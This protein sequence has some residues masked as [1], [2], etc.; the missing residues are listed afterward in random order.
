MVYRIVSYRGLRDGGLTL[1][2]LLFEDWSSGL[3]EM[4]CGLSVSL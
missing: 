2:G 4:R 3:E 1:R